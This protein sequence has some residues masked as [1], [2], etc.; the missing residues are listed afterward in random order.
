MRRILTCLA[1]I[2]GFAPLGGCNVFTSIK[3]ETS[4]EYVL[5]GWNWAPFVIYG[6]VYA[7]TYDPATKTMTLRRIDK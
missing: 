6:T 3:R 4:G 7:G 2:C 1:L 5:T